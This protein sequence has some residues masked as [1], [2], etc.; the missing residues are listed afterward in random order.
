MESPSASAEWMRGH[1]LV[2]DVG[3]PRGVPQVHVGVE[4]LSQP[5]VLGQRGRLDEPGV[6]HQALVVEG[7]ID[8]VEAV[9]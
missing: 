1:G 4:K 8:G 5:Q 3:P 2:A 7:H 9:R 6:G